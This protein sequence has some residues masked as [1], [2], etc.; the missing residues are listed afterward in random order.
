[1]TVPRKGL[2][3]ATI[4]TLKKLAGRHARRLFTPTWPAGKGLELE[5]Y[6]LRVSALNRSATLPSSFVIHWKNAGVGVNKQIKRI[7]GFK[8]V[9]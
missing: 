4:H 6:G 3:S 8:Q 9:S 2:F 1:M 7:S 5:I